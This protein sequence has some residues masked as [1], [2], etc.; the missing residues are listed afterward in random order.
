MKRIWFLLFPL[1]IANAFGEGDI[2]PR[3]PKRVLPATDLAQLISDTRIGEPQQYKNLAVFP[4]FTSG[5][6]TRRYWTL[7]Q[8]LVKGVLRISE[9][10]EGSVPELLAENRSDEPIFLMAGEIVTG[11]KQNRVVSQ[12]ILLAP[13]SGPVGLGVFCV[14]QGR[15]TQQARY[16]GV[17]KE[18]AHATLRQSLSAPTVSQGMVWGEVSRITEALAAAQPNET[19][20]LGKIYEAGEV[21]R[22]LDDYT[23][24]IVWTQDA[25]G[26]AVMIGGR[27]VGAELFGDAET[28]ASLR[29]KL[30]RSYAV[31]AI[32]SVDSTKVG[33][34]REA[35]ERFLRNAQ[36]ARLSRKDTIGVGRLSGIEG[37]SVYSSVLTWHEQRGAHGVVHA[38]LFEDL[39]ADIRP[40]VVPMPRPLP[41]YRD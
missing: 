38:S 11:G 14:E 24:A 13:R 35:V 22:D 18:M 41:R 23:R 6:A 17:E 34:G 7:D 1:V 31:D 2:E 36:Q 39:R 25:N 19:R 30:L 12:D 26:M 15:W 27:V 40:P 21:K 29:D 20:Y 10:G 5:R 28:F 32:E 8:A 37:R 33:A 16:F 3:P 9:K 4:L